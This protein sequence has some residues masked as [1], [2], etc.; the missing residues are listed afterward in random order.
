LTMAKTSISWKGPSRGRY[1]D[2]ACATASRATARGAPTARPHSQLHPDLREPSPQILL[3]RASGLLTPA[4][5]ESA[6]VPNIFSGI[7][8]PFQTQSSRNGSTKFRGAE[9]S[10]ENQK[11]NCQAG[12]TEKDYFPVARRS[13]STRWRQHGGNTEAGHHRDNQ[14]PPSLLLVPHLAR[15]HRRRRLIRPSTSAAS[16]LSSEA[17]RRT[18]TEARRGGRA[19]REREQ[20]EGELR[21]RKAASCGC[22]RRREG[23][24]SASF[25]TAVR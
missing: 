15:R 13:G 7:S 1:W 19:H 3:V 6:K 10:K 14:V 23:M 5:A 17:T 18:G 25:T 9:I 20:H 21:V 4:P 11:G 24:A 12:W 16:A 8:P 22:G 2:S